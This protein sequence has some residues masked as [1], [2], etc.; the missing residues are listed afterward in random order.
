MFTLE[1]K[2]GIED[3]G[4]V[5]QISAGRQ[6]LA[7]LTTSGNGTCMKFVLACQYITIGLI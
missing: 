6:H 5:S 3:D 1:V 4:M 2:L 7:V